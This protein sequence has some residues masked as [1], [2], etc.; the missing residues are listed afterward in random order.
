MK[1]YKTIGPA[2]L[3]T[4]IYWNDIEIIIDRFVYALSHGAW[5]AISYWMLLGRER[6]AQDPPWKKQHAASS[7]SFSHYHWTQIKMKFG[8]VPS[9]KTPAWSV[10]VLGNGSPG[11]HPGSQQP[12]GHPIKIL[13]HIYFLSSYMHM[14]H[15]VFIYTLIQ[16]GQEH[17]LSDVVWRHSWYSSSWIGQHH[18]LPLRINAICYTWHG[19]SRSG[20]D[21]LQGCF[22][23]DW[24]IIPPV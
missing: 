3:T 9:K 5:I 23:L 4:H 19:L 16:A 24:K 20:S 7:L 17:C 13:F 11:S 15:V 1:H 22:E 10:W 21:A 2:L 6:A 14:L 8:S 18:A 12:F